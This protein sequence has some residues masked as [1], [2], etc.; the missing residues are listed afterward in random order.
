M[1][2]IAKRAAVNMYAQLATMAIT[3]TTKLAPHARAIVNHAL[4]ILFALHVIL[5]TS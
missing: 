5:I 1:R 2:L 4:P 3:L